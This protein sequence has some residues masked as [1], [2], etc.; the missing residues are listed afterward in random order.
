MSMPS[1]VLLNAFLLCRHVLRILVESGPTLFLID[2]H[3]G[4]HVPRHAHRSVCEH[5]FH[6][7][8]RASGKVDGGLGNAEP[9]LGGDIT[10]F[11]HIRVS[12]PLSAVLPWGF[13]K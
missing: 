3:A 10:H 9:V 6:V 2:R 12:I 5:H 1:R 8:K 4:R 7:V 13:Y 11:S